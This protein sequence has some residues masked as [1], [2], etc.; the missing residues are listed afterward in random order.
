MAPCSRRTRVS[1]YERRVPEFI[2]GI[3]LCPVLQ[4]PLDRTE[5]AMRG[6]EVEGRALVERLQAAQIFDV[7][8][9]PR[10]LLNVA[11][12]S[13]HADAVGALDVAHILRAHS[14]APPAPW[15]F[16]GSLHL[17]LEQLI[18]DDRHARPLVAGD[19]GRIPAARPLLQA[20]D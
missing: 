10:E 3:D 7:S 13:E 8:K 4:Q 15:R 1:A 19:R 20:S 2:D 16:G 5:L 12:L 11:L 18:L 9:H 14:A 6:G 17:Q